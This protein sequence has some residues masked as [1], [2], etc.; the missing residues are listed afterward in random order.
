MVNK[1]I[2]VDM[3]AT[4]IHHGHTRLLK[5]ASS[6]GD[7]IIGLTTDDEILKKKGYIPELDYNSRKEI[8]QSI[9]Y[10]KEVVPTPWKINDNILLEYNIDLLVHGDD[11][12]NNVDIKKLLIFPRT[13]G[14]CSSDLRK[15]SFN[16]INNIKKNIL[17]NPGPATTTDT[18]KLAQVVPDICPRENEFGNLMKDVSHE[19][20]NLVANSQEY[21]TILFGGSGTAAV[22]SILT[23]VVQDNKAILI[24]NNGAYGKRMCEIAKRYN[25]NYIEFRSS[26]IE[27]IELNMLETKIKS[28]SNISHIA[29]V[30]NETTT[31][32]LTDLNQIGN[33]VKKH[34][35]ELVV[36]GMSS[37]GAI[38]I[39]MIKSNISFLAASSNKNIQ[40]MAGVGFVIANKKSLETIKNVSPKTFY[41]SLYEQY[42]NFKIKNQMRFTPP[43]QTIYALKQA[44]DELKFEGIENRYIRYSNSWNVLTEFLKENNIKYLVQDKDHSKI[45]TSIVLPEKINFIHLHDYFYNRGFTI[46]PGKIEEYNTFRIANIGNIDQNDLKNFCDLLEIYLNNH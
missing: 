46:Y 25:V 17:L 4:L 12:T 39:D 34:K 1:R 16:I 7:V 28:H 42:E 13:E 20:T 41:L 36:D 31:G 10:V 35:I 40:G 3:S 29:L 27:Q 37:F 6:Y 43:V 5:K 19:L 33:L 21:C 45:I 32:L 8:L 2:M 38:P 24:V 9:K 22:E 15:N 18:V 23:S 11:N 26:P 30:H 14:V 44:I